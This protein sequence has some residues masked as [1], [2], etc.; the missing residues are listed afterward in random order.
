[1]KIIDTVAPVVLSVPTECRKTHTYV[2]PRDLKR[3]QNIKI[4]AKSERVFIQLAFMP[5]MS[6]A[7]CRRTE[8]FSTGRLLRFQ[9]D[10]A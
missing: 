5:E 9:G 6:V 7:M 4:K 8:F 1:M 3:R 10:L 2:D